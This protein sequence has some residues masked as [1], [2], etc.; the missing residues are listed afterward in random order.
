V[1]GP[2][3]GRKPREGKKNGR[4]T[5][6]TPAVQTAIVAHLRAG[7]YLETAANLAGLNRTTVFSWLRQGA[8]TKDPDSPHKR[9]LDAVKEAESYAEA[10]ALE[11]LR[12]H[13]GQYWQAEAWYL[14]RRHPRRWGRKDREPVPESNADEARETLANRDVRRLLDEASRKLD[15]ARKPRR[16]GGDTEPGEVE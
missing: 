6:L 9:F 1:G 13:G 16:N 8:Q 5:A 12:A 11:R 4:P 10:D 7:N 15:V 14:E 2:G 3:S